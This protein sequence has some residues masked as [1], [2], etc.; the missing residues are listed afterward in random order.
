MICTTFAVQVAVAAKKATVQTPAVAHVKPIPWPLNDYE[1]RLVCYECCGT[2]N[3]HECRMDVLVARRRDVAGNVA[4]SLWCQ[5]RPRVNHMDLPGEYMIRSS[6][7]YHTEIKLCFSSAYKDVEKEAWDLEKRGQFDITR[8]IK[9]NRTSKLP[10][11]ST[12]QEILC[13]YPV[14]L[15]K[16]IC[17]QEHCKG[18]AAVTVKLSV[19]LYES[20]AEKLKNNVKDLH[21]LQYLCFSN[22]L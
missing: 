7:W 5:I 21:F 12:T 11:L 22:A 4:Q 13:E 1:W 2:S 6:E 19:C 9:S 18:S 20:M 16:K 17:G 14:S 15:G 10:L 8:F 3:Q